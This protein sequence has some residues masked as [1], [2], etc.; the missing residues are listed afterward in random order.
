MKKI[1]FLINVTWKMNM[2]QVAW[3]RATFGILEKP[4]VPVSIPDVV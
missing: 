3:V 1:R 2:L 4:L